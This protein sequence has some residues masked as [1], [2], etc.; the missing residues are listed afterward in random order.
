MPPEPQASSPPAGTGAANSRP[1][2]AVTNDIN[3]GSQ[4]SKTAYVTEL[5]ESDRLRFAKQI[6]SGIAIISTGVFAGYAAL[7]D[8]KA[9]AAVFELVKIGAL[10]IVTLVISFYFPNSSK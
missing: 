8:N 7:P 4:F 2:S 3:V 6:L 1:S 10:P 5:T 9:L